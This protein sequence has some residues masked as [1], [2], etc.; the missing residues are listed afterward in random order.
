VPRSP[1]LLGNIIQASLGRHANV[2]AVTEPAPGFLEIKL[3]ADPPAG[4]WHPGHEIQFRVTPTE[5]RRYT[6]HTVSGTHEDLID[7]LVA[8]DANGPG[9]DWIR[10]LRPG[11]EIILLASRYVPLRGETNSRLYLGD[12]STL[13]TIDAY[14][15]SDHDARAVIEAPQHAITSL[16]HNFPRIRFVHAMGTPGDALQQWLH[17]AVEDGSLAHLAGVHLLGHAQSIQRQR[18]TLL[19]EQVFDRRAISSRPYWAT[20][21]RGL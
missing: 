20:G 11:A 15:R 18:R 12:G 7:I 4:G 17:A 19:D 3:H 10:A 1:A 21:R 8:T 6:V 9:T 2:L 5:G 13:G 14:A 16:A